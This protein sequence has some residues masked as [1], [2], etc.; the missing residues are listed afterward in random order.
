MAHQRR[1]DTLPLMPVHHH[2]GQLSLPGL[3]DDVT[4]ATND[5]RPPAFFHHG[6]QRYMFDKIDIQVESDFLFCEV[7]SWSEET[8]VERGAAGFSDGCEEIRLVVRPEGADFDTAPTAQ[9]LERQ[10]LGCFQHG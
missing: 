10:I 9:R 3:L 5:R 4:T 6:D 8:T 7:A 1:A 2:E